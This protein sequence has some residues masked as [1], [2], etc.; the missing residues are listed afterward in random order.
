ML[1]FYAFE[2]TLLLILA[3]MA[4]TTLENRDP[5]I[6][7]CVELFIYVYPIVLIVIFLFPQ[8]LEYYQTNYKLTRY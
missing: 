2:I 7:L 1:L 4:K 8:A 5:K 3:L 6:R